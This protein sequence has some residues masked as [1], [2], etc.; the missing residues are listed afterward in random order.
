M[1]ECV[2]KDVLDDP[3]YKMLQTISGDLTYKLFFFKAVNFLY[4]KKKFYCMF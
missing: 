2:I 3:N 4:P 1:L